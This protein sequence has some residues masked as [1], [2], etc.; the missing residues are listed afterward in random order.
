[1]KRAE[2]IYNRWGDH[3]TNGRWLVAIHVGEIPDRDRPIRFRGAEEE[4][5][6]RTH[7]DAL[8]HALAEVG[9][10]PTTEREN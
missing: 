5:G 3:G 8:A 10:T 4:A 7:A 2:V 6:F 1:M 9:L